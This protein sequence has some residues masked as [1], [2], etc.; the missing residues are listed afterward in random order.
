M[1]KILQVR[2]ES[3]KKKKLE[4]EVRNRSCRALQVIYNGVQWE[5]MRIFELT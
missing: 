1:V 2:E 4:E 5:A 3:H